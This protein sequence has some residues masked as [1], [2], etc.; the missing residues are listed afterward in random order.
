MPQELGAPVPMG[1]AEKTLLAP[2]FGLGQPRDV[3]QG[4][5]DCLPVSPLSVALHFKLKKNLEKEGG[6]RKK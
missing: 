5:E 6:G 3:N 4:V 1:E 2:G